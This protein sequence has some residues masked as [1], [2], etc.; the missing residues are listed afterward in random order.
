MASC[1]QDFPFG[2]LDIVELLH[3]KIRRRQAN[4][5]YVDCQICGDKRGKLNVNFVKNVWRCNYC[6]EGGGML[7]LYAKVYGTSTSDAYRE[8]CDALQTGG[9][10]PGYE[11]KQTPSK[12]NTHEVPQSELAG[13]QEIH[14]TL[15]LLFGMLS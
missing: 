9:Q 14:Q 10:A 8:I 7:S 1:P 6:D 11:V 3:L 4:S 5:I 12:E 13:I 15:S 2:I